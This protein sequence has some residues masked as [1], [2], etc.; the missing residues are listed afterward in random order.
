M[1]GITQQI[2]DHFDAAADHARCAAMVATARAD[3]SP[4]AASI[5]HFIEGGGDAE[6]DETPTDQ[7]IIDCYCENFGGTPEQAYA[8][9]AKMAAP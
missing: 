7:E 1:N 5:R 3:A 8:R 4:I 6:Y 2:A 9:L